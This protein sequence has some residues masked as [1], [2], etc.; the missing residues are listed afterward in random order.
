MATGLN[1]V[2][3]PVGQEEAFRTLSVTLGLVATTVISYCFAQRAYNVDL[4]SRRGLSSINI[5]KW[6]LLGLFVDS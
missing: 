2:V 6:L 1:S 4:F 3:Y 5:T